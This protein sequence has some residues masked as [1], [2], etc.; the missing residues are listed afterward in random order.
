M[1][2]ISVASCSPLTLAMTPRTYLT[3]APV[4]TRLLLTV[5]DLHLTVCPHEAAGT[6]TG[7]AALAG[8]LTDPSISTGRVVGAVVQVYKTHRNVSNK[9][10]VVNGE[11]L[12]VLEKTSC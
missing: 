12:N 1:I 2:T 7:V 8:V 11:H 4:G 10:L 9:A 5:V 3:G 6:V